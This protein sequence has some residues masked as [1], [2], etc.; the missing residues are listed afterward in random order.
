MVA[1]KAF[2]AFSC[3]PFTASRYLKVD[4]AI[5]CDTGEHNGAKG[6]AA[7]AILM[8]PIGLIVLNAVLLYRAR[9]AIRSNR[10]TALSNA[11]AFLHREFEPHVFWWELVEML[12]RF[13]LVGV[14]VL[15]QNTMMQLVVGTL[16]AAAFLLF[17]VQASPY[18]NMS[19]DL[20]ASSLGRRHAP[21]GV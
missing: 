19:D 4:V 21:M 12:R 10:P 20:L 17:Q 13:V 8:Y 11:I 3:Y 2:E 6:L 15:Y 5:R 14:M 16:L 1:T 18:V 7:I 9:K